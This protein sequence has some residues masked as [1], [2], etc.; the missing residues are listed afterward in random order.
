MPAYE[1]EIDV[2]GD[3]Q[4]KQHLREMG[5]RALFAEPALE[6]VV[7]VLRDSERAIFSRGRSWAPNAPSTIERKG[8]NDPLHWTGALERSLTE[9]GD[10]NELKEIGPDSLRWGSKLWYAHFALGTKKQPKREVVKLRVQ[11]RARIVG[12]LREWILH[13]EKGLSVGV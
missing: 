4:I 11:D 13:G 7:G 10:D 6:E 8:R 1:L 2:L 5:D 3:E 9:E 12:I